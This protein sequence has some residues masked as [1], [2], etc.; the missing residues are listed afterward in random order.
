MAYCPNCGSPLKNGICPACGFSSEI[1]I[2]KLIKNKD[3]EK[4]QDIIEKELAKNPNDGKYNLLMTRVLTK[5]FSEKPRDFE[6]LRRHATIGLTFATKE[7]RNKIE[8][9]LTHYFNNHE[10]GGRGVENVFDID[11]SQTVANAEYNSFLH[12]DTGNGETVAAAGKTKKRRM[13]AMG[14][15]AKIILCSALSVVLISGVVVGIVLGRDNKSD[16]SDN[17]S[18]SSFTV[19]LY[20]GDGTYQF[21]TTTMYYNSYTSVSVPHK[22]GYIFDGYYTS[23]EGDGTKIF[24]KY[25]EQVSAWRSY[26]ETKLYANWLEEDVGTRI[27]L[28]CNGG[29]MS[30]S[31]TITAKFNETMEDLNSNQIPTNTGYVFDGFWSSLSGGTQYFDRDGEA[32]RPWNEISETYT[33]YAH[34]IAITNIY[35]DANGGSMSGSHYATASYNSM[36]DDLNSDQ[37]PTKTGYVF[38]GYWSSSFG[39]TEYFDKYGDACKKWD[40]SSS[41]YTLY[42]HWTISTTSVYLECYPGSASGSHY[43]TAT[44]G[45]V[46]PNL[47]S[48]QIPTRYGYVFN[49]FWSSSSGGTQYYDK[50]G[51]GL[52]TWESSSP[53][54]TIY[55]QWIIQSE[56]RLNSN[57]GSIVGSTYIYLNYGETPDDLPVNQLATRTG[58][59]FNGYWSSSSGGTQYFDCNGKALRSWDNTSSSFTL[60][61][62][63]SST[64]TVYL[65]VNGGTMSGSTSYSMTNINS[66]SNLSS[67]QLPTKSGYVFAGYYSTSSKSGTQYFDSKGVNVHAFSNTG[68][69]TLYAV[70]ESASSVYSLTYS[71]FSVSSSEF[72][73]T[74]K[75]DNSTGTLT[76]TFSKACDVSFSYSVSSEA[77]YDYFRCS[78]YPSTSSSTSESIFSISGSNSGTKSL[79]VNANSKLVFT[80]TKDYTSSSGSDRGSITNFVVK[81]VVF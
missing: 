59:F 62:H 65:N 18:N 2:E 31:T 74:N 28:N 54:S 38:D 3:Y 9:K 13:P 47:T 17:S 75:T 26:Y 10:R 58:Y 78:Y 30:G 1:D 70:Y 71:S 33:L 34:W 12:G 76:I 67:S 60:Y 25:G 72:Y 14:K 7:E 20:Y 27:Y 24:D 19:R 50:N 40:Y 36:P 6:E 46:L 5:N 16:Y 41:T 56:V 8:Y 77:S 37:I 21:T 79:S 45:S 29:S 43:I 44:Y 69:T 55:A 51:Y 11:A 39:G 15:K 80:Y 57:S 68:P 4:A 61:A 22:D 66:P 81:N 73:S 32:K 48:S 35:L 52:V 64:Y 49:G 53:S 63:W 23:T 42:A